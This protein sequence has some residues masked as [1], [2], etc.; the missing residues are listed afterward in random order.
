[1]H[2]FSPIA[3]AAA[4]METALI[5]RAPPSDVRKHM[6][7]LINRS[8]LARA[9]WKK[10]QPRALNGEVGFVDEGSDAKASHANV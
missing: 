5:N 1:M 4:A 9:S 10:V 2:G 3:E 8:L 6:D 7:Q